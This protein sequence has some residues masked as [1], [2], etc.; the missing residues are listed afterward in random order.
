M[1][2]HKAMH[3]AYLIYN[4]H[5]EGL[6]QLELELKNSHI[7][8]H[9]IDYFVQKVDTGSVDDVRSIRSE[10]TKKPIASSVR[11]VVLSVASLHEEA[12][13]MLL[14]T[15]EEPAQ[16]VIVVLVVPPGT[17]LLPTLLSRVRILSSNELAV[18]TL[19]FSVQTFLSS[20]PKERLTLVESITKSDDEDTL[21]PKTHALELLRGAEELFLKQA[22][23]GAVPATTALEDIE[24]MRS[25]LFQ[26]G[27][28][29]KYI[30]EYLAV[31]L[32]KG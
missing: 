24:K 15:F 20:S 11:I 1:M 8:C 25:L 32:P 7:Q 5:A 22:I 16:S 30:L 17:P 3:H 14:K 9:P 6:Q 12:Q 26:K 31:S 13:H 19:P 4:S 21:K 29:T 28:V 27:T 23:N 2:Y 18:T 10:A